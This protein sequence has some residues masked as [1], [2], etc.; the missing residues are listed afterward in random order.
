[1]KMHCL[2]VEDQLMFLELLL[3]ALGR[4]PYIEV[5]ATATSLEA[6]FREA[7]KQKFDV[8]I[9]DYNLPDG[10]GLELAKTLHEEQ[11]E[12]EFIML[13]AHAATFGADALHEP[14][15]RAVID[16][17]RTFEALMAELDSLHHQRFPNE[18]TSS[19]PYDTLTSREREVFKL[20]G[21]GLLNKQIAARLFISVGTVETH[22]KSVARKLGVSGSELVRKS[23]LYDHPLI[24]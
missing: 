13:S 24:P 17:V 20:I 2:V 14:H 6:A 9:L 11:P 5:S 12:L 21:D 16:K 4:L 8:V 1:M 15:I 3:I 22:R 23:A 18:I 10:C 7:R 19:D